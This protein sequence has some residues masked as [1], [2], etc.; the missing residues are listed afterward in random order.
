MHLNTVD[1]EDAADSGPVYLMRVEQLELLGAPV[2]VV[3]QGDTV[4]PALVL[5]KITLPSLVS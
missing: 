1:L 2:E 5:V 3:M 4:A